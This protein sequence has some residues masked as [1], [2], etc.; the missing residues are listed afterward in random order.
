MQMTI[1]IPDEYKA[2]IEDVSGKTGLRKSDIA[3]M[4]IKKFL[5]DFDIQAREDRPS[6]KVQDLIG[7]VSSG[8]SDLGT[9]HRQHLLNLMREPKQ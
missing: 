3:R 2:R 8:I 9:N 4:A 1:R 5:E 7:V 6:G